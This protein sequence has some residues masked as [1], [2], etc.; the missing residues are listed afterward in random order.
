[1]NMLEEYHKTIEFAVIGSDELT[2]KE[3]EGLDT[4]EGFVIETKSTDLWIRRELKIYD[5]LGHLTVME[6]ASN[7]AILDSFGISMWTGDANSVVEF[8]VGWFEE[9]DI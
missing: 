5:V 4:K 9:G 1:M 2:V 3:V 7:Y 8:V 6:D